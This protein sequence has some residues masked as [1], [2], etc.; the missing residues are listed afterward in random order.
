[1]LTEFINLVTSEA[2]EICEK[3]SKKTIAAEHIIEALQVRQLINAYLG[4]EL[5]ITK[6]LEFKD[7][8]EQLEEVGK[9]FKQTARVSFKFPRSLISSESIQKDRTE[10]RGA[11]LDKLGLTTEE[12]QA[13][14]ELLFAKSRALVEGSTTAEGSAAPNAES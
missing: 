4:I 7:Y 6:S 8:V 2:N 10:K 14:Q 1:M 13:Q 12:L 9:D 5:I 3:G 11:K